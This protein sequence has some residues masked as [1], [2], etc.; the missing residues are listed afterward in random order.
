VDDW[1]GS[2]KLGVW[3]A[4]SVAMG[5]VAHYKFE[6]FWG[7]SKAEIVSARSAGEDVD[8]EDQADAKLTA[9]VTNA[10]SNSA[11]P[12]QVT[13]PTTLTNSYGVKVGDT[14]EISALSPAIALRRAT[15]SA[16]DTN[17][18]TVRSGVDE[19]HVRWKDVAK[20]KSAGK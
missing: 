16:L 8:D 19:Y 2:T 13:A 12:V 1:W 4:V 14:V 6:Q 3:I 15:V 10:A 9:K 18:I 7:D 11:T 17:Q 5:F 20:L